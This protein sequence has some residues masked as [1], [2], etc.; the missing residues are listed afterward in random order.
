[1]VN[2]LLILNKQRFLSKY[3]LDSGPHGGGGSDNP[4]LQ[5]AAGLLHAVQ[6]LRF[7][8]IFANILVIVFEILIGGWVSYSR[9]VLTVELVHYEYEICMDKKGGG[10]RKV[11]VGCTR[12][13]SRTKQRGDTLFYFERRET[14]TWKAALHAKNLCNN[15][16]RKGWLLFTCWRGK[17]IPAV[18]KR[19]PLLKILR[20]GNTFQCTR[21][22]H[23]DLVNERLCKANL[24]NAV[25]VSCDQPVCFHCTSLLSRG[26]RVVEP[27]QPL[28][29][30]DNLQIH[31]GFQSIV[32]HQAN[33][34]Y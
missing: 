10:C 14:E 21:C 27:G 9:W 17:N 2:A 24:Q 12:Q 28:H 3:G 23:S 34:K 30:I 8:V 19:L 7:P 11:R 25:Y 1:M 20:L 16:H 22:S 31:S 6:Y 18:L 15:L 33:T 29:V 13:C 32:R 4:L 5:Q 26:C